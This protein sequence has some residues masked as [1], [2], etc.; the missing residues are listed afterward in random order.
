MKLHSNQ[1]KEEIKKIGKQIDSK[2]TFGETVLGSSELNAVTPSFQGG[3]LKSVMKQLEIDSNIEIPVG[4]EVNYKFGLLVNGEYEYLDFG[5]YIVKE[6]EKQEDT[7]SYKITC[8]DK[9]L[10]LVCI[11]F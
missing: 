4:T 8:Y 2:I 6:V 3:I 10:L 9:L 1:F 5:N 11:E 7:L